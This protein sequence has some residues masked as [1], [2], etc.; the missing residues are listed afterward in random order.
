[1]DR[2]D[3]H[4][5]LLSFLFQM[6]GRGPSGM[7][8]GHSRPDLILEL[9]LSPRRKPNGRQTYVDN[10]LFASSCSILPEWSH[11]FGTS[12]TSYPFVS[13]FSI[14]N[15]QLFKHYSLLIP[16][17]CA[18]YCI[19]LSLPVHRHTERVDAHSVHP[20][21]TASKDNL[22]NAP[23]SGF[24][25]T[26]RHGPWRRTFR[27]PNN[28]LEPQLIASQSPLGHAVSSLL[29]IF[30]SRPTPSIFVDCRALPALPSDH[31]G[32]FLRAFLS[33]NPS[34]ALTAFGPTGPTSTRAANPIVYCPPQ[35]PSE[36][37][38]PSSH[39]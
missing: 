18:L 35:P 6:S 17:A 1:M 36:A 14:L 23:F 22:A 31:G 33:I 5:W 21:F 11:R 10:P 27:Q 2:M 13:H 26:P 30:S 38:F 15:S 16:L 29:S 3:R 7:Y 34:A 24:N 37:P 28:A 9:I 32:V 12:T 19:L 8:N 39:V 25:S 4:H 20:T